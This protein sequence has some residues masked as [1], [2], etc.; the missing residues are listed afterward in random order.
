MKYSEQCHEAK[1][2]RVI[3]GE[4]PDKLLRR[5]QTFPSLKFARRDAVQPCKERHMIRGL[6]EK[7][8]RVYVLHRYALQ[9]SKHS[10]RMW[11]IL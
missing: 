5:P 11:L 7:S 10:G 4:I 6:L 1:L 9:N 2:T 3:G 8:N